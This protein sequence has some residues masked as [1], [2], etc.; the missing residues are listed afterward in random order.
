VVVTA[1]DLAKIAPRSRVLYRRSVLPDRQDAIYMGQPVALLIFEQFDA[2]DA[3]RLALRDGT[4]VKFARKPV[5]SPLTIMAPFVLRASA[6]LDAGRSR[7]LFAGPGRLGVAGAHPEH[8][9]PVWSSFARKRWRPTARPRFMA[10]RSAAELD[11]KNPALLVL[12]PHLETQSVDPV[13][14]DRNAG[15]VVNREKTKASNSC[16]AFNRPTGGRVDRVPAGTSPRSRSK[17]ARINTQF[18]YLGGAFGGR[19]HTPSCS[20]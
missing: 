2:F 7:C 20:M 9:A 12:E 1:E 19:D 14:L 17:P 4:F 16:S 5:P 18:T 3:A 8:R 11:R 13:F 10:S 6:G 15:S